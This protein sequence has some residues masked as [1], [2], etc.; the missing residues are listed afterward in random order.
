MKKL[1][2][3][4]VAMAIAAPLLTAFGCAESG[5]KPYSLTGAQNLTGD[6][7]RWVD[8]HSID[9]KGHFNPTLHQQALSQMTSAN[10]GAL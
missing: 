2:S 10:Q 1:P 9:Q 7:Q 8:Q 4:I 3:V 5:N 6:Q